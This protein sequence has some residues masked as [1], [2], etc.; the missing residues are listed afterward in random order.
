LSFTCPVCRRTS[1]NPN[2]ESAG[3][4]GYCHDFTGTPKY[5][6]YRPATPIPRERE[7]DDDTG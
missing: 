3:Y 1:H 5:E 2:D 7:D 6:S 4:C